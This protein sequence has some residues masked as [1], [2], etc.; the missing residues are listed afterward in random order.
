[1]ATVSN[2]AAADERYF[3]PAPSRWPI[4][5]AIALLFFV[6]GAAVWLNRGGSGPYLLGIG[7][8]ALLLVLVGW[9]SDVSGEGRYYNGQG[10]RSLHWGMAWL[11]VDNAIGVLHFTLANGAYG[12]TFYVLT[13]LHG[14]HVGIGATMVAVMLVRALLGRITPDNHV[15]FDM[16]AWYWHF[17][18]VVWLL[19]FV[20]VYCL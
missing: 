20:V 5:S 17:V 6:A 4:R 10:D 9:F 3:V 11:I 1:M 15:A 18:G 19:L 2:P 8:L 12:A 7:L 13:G 16:V 14:L